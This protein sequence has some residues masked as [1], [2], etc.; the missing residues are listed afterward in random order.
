M[1]GT[2]F[3][4]SIPHHSSA[5]CADAPS[6]P[7]E[8]TVVTATEN[9]TI[10]SGPACASIL[11]DSVTFNTYLLTSFQRIIALNL[12]CL[13]SLPFSAYTLEWSSDVTGRHDYSQ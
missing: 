2:P 12:P 3:Q 7:L 6:I 10:V 4:T 9:A 8:I 1:D 11:S 13:S 5:Y